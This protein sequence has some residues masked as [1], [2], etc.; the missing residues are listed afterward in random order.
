MFSF[1]IALDC[2]G[3]LHWPP[4]KNPACTDARVQE[5][6]GESISRQPAIN[7]SVMTSPCL[8]QDTKTTFDCRFRGVGELPKHVKPRTQATRPS[9][10]RVYGYC[11]GHKT[12]ALQRDGALGGVSATCT[13]PPPPTTYPC[14]A[15]PLRKASFVPSAAKVSQWVQPVLLSSNP[16][17]PPLFSAQPCAWH[18][19]CLGRRWSA[20]Y[21]RCVRAH[22]PS[23]INMHRVPVLI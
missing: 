22:A 1:S 14:A 10:T 2:L 4:N 17:L 13:R 19:H 7:R 12:A 11:G 20:V 3:T 9:R 15:G 18:S 23:H 5:E 8:T 21:P 16:L 6:L